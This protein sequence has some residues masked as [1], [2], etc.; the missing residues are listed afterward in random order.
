[1]VWG[2]V[3]ISDFKMLHIKTK[4][5]DSFKCFLFVDCIQYL[6]LKSMGILCLLNVGQ[7]CLRIVQELF[8]L[9]V[10]S[11]QRKYIAPMTGIAMKGQQTS[12]DNYINMLL[13][14]VTKVYVAMIM[15]H[16]PS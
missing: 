7:L 5:W 16:R 12:D 11:V 15:L 4:G 2:N 14:I 8:I 10:G 3:D 1:M 9:S 6:L 13:M